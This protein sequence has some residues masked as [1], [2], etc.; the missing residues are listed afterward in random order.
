M[1]EIGALEVV[2]GLQAS[3]FLSGL[4]NAEKAMTGFVVGIA[5]AAK[6]S[7]EAAAEAQA[8]ASQVAGIFGKLAPEVNAFSEQLGAAAGRA[9]SDIQ[10][11]VSKFGGMLAP[12][13]ASKATA[14]QMSEGLT[15]MAVN[16]EKAFHVDSATAV[17]ALTSALA[18]S[19]RAARQYG[20]DLSE[21]A[22]K[23]QMLKDGIS[24]QASELSSAQRSMVMYQLVMS[25]SADMAARAAKAN[26][27]YS[28]QMKQLDAATKEAAEK[29]GGDLLPAASA[30][31]GVVGGLA[32]AFADLSPGMREAIEISG[33]LI[34][35][36]GLL[37]S[38][39]ALWESELAASAVA[40]IAA[41]GA[42]AIAA[43][44]LV[45]VVAGVA[46]AVGFLYHA[47]ET[48]LGGIKQ[49][50]ADAVQ[51]IQGAFSAAFEW[52]SKTGA[53]AWEGLKDG[54][55][56]F[57]DAIFAMLEG[58]MEAWGK[59][60]EFIGKTMHQDWAMH[61]STSVQGAV[62]GME[63]MRQGMTSGNMGAGLQGFVSPIVTAVSN[64]AAAAMQ[65]GRDSLQGLKDGFR[66]LLAQLPKGEADALAPKIMAL[67]KSQVAAGAGPHAAT[68]TAIGNFRTDDMQEG[69]S[70]QM[71]PV[72][73]Q[74]ILDA[75]KSATGQSGTKLGPQSG[76]AGTGAG[77]VDISVLKTASE[78]QKLVD[79]T[80]T[81]I[82]AV[83]S[84]T[85]ITIA[86]QIQVVKATVSGYDWSSLAKSLGDQVKSSLGTLGT[87]LNAA[88]Q[89]GNAAGPIGAIAAA[90]LS[91]LMQ[92]QGFQQTMK[93]VTTIVSLLANT[94]GQMMQ[95]V[96]TLLGM[97]Q[98]VI[99]PLVSAITP[100]LQSLATAIIAPLEQ[101]VSLL[102][103]VFSALTTVFKALQAPLDAIFSVLSSAI[104]PVLN[105]L[106][107][108]F[109]AVGEA[110]SAIAPILTALTPII[111]LVGQAFSAMQPV[112]IAIGLALG[113]VALIIEAVVLGLAEAWNAILTAV[114][115]LLSAIGAKS[116]AASVAADEI[117]TGGIED[118][119][120]QIVDG[121]GSLLNGTTNL[122][123]ATDQQTVAAGALTAQMDQATAS[124][125]NLPSG[126][127][128]A[129]QEFQSMNI[130]SPGSSTAAG[131]AGNSGAPIVLA[132]GGLVTKTGLAYIHAGEQV[133]PP[134][135]S[136]LASAESA[137]AAPLPSSSSQSGGSAGA[138]AMNVSIT[139]VS[140][141]P[142]AAGPAVARYLK[143]ISRAQFGRPAPGL[144]RFALPNDTR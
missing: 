114:A 28:E 131:I 37:S 92:S 65:I 120:T 40:A 41:F 123:A 139:I 43:A 94:L 107:P 96:S 6:K 56:I 49:V 35:A 124:L 34:V 116:A 32:H 108:V 16:M 26:G 68:S 117:N 10:G 20:I 51:S 102:Q 135:T 122:S 61:I 15:E 87:V 81:G 17:G 9:T 1:A 18:G 133:V 78:F 53:S 89:G 128:I 112:W 104:A 74:G 143:K 21:A 90:A 86:Q 64:G 4:S 80:Q 84:G 130:Q 19:A 7:I 45:A 100:I 11:M 25:Q 44:P 111:S 36:I 82:M 83:I 3:E 57:R 76:V 91:L 101:I 5:E 136:G 113:V 132:S 12:M 109:N 75:F 70:R 126:Y 29:F 144:G 52:I 93:V 27:D 14:A 77:T 71:S 54:A 121:M 38:A 55:A 22:V 103:P 2:L 118:S 23:S 85:Q 127:R 134:G 106:A 50:V 140:N 59:A 141:N 60:F 13:I 73:T 66:D 138:G 39:T 67:T 24:G 79:D 31:L 119:M 110:M 63:G 62:G 105:I 30:L 129:L 88:I 95:P 72:I 142:D 8:A 47:W 58:V 33:G 99:L 69:A 115:G 46:L 97:I 137:T 98:N 125:T 48:N 42:A